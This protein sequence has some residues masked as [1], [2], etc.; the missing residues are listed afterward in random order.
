MLRGLQ[1][2]KS[3]L[4]GAHKPKQEANS[5]FVSA[6]RNMLLAKKY[7]ANTPWTN[8]SYFKWEALVRNE[9]AK[10]CNISS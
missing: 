10:W 3:Q 9:S 5:P 6:W 2:Y 7:F 4:F 1:F 8:F